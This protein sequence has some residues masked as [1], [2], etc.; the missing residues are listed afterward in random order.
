MKKR[1]MIFM[2]GFF[3]GQKYGGP[4]V[5]VNN[6][7]NLLLD[8]VSFFIVTSDHDLRSSEKYSVKE[9]WKDRGNCS[10]RYISDNEWKYKFLKQLTDE[11]KPDIIYLQ[12]FFGSFIPICYRIARKNNIPLF[13]A[14]RGELCEGSVRIKRYKKIPYLALI[15]LFGFAKNVCFQATSADEEAGIEKF[16]KIPKD[17]IF[18]LDNVS[19]PP[20]MDA[21]RTKKE[22]GSANMIF[23]SRISPKKNLEAAVTYLTKVKNVNVKFDIYGP[24]EDNAYWEKCKSISQNA[25]ENISVSYKRALSHEEVHDVLACYDAFL[26]PTFSENF[27]HVIAES[28][29]AGTP[30]IISD[31]TP[32]NEVNECHAGYAFPLSE[33]Q[34]Y[35]YAINEIADMDEDAMNAMRENAKKLFERR[36]NLEEIKKEYMKVFNQLG[37]N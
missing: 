12:S 34:K 35:I 14:P 25:S 9:G 30:V 15:R 29:S 20:R 21:S 33:E 6:I 18:F 26:F 8:E 24:L 5:S 13:L 1:I 2:G 11:I 22:K 23:I 7:C 16:L 28:L 19:V 27:G 37:E 17:R 3:P 31:Q 4:P 32:W 36:L 10:V